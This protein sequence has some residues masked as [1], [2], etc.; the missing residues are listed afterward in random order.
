[1]KSEHN[2]SAAKGMVVCVLVGTCRQLYLLMC[3]SGSVGE[4]SGSH[5]G[6]FHALSNS[7]WAHTDILTS[8][9]ICTEVHMRRHAQ[10]F[11]YIHILG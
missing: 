7:F 9:L 1:M 5:G 8:M 2:R 3:M 10:V 6:T 11:A 4:Q